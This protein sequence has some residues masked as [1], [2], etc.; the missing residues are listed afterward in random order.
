MRPSF[1]LP[2]D[3]RLSEEVESLALIREPDAPGRTR[4]A[5][6][7]VETAGRKEVERRMR[8]AGLEVHVDGAGNL[9]GVLEGRDAGSAIV[10][11]SHTDTVLGGGRFDGIVGVLGALEAV[12]CLAEAGVRLRHD[13]W[14]VD[15]YGEEPNDFGLSCLGSSGRSSAT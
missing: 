13:L 6:S 9:V 8:E 7:E 4:R 14:V 2:E 15:F 5:L 10:T 1:P 3:E 11:G 12:A